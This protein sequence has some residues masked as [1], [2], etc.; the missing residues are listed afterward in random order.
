MKG[1]VFTLDALFALMIAAIGIAIVF[2]FAYTAPTPYMIQSSVATGLLST[3]GSSTIGQISGIPLAGYIIN[4]SAASNQT[5]TMQYANQYNNA[6]NGYGPSSLM[7]AYVI[8][9]NATIINGTIVAGYGN[10]YFGAG[11]TIYAINATTGS[12]IWT[13]N[14]PYNSIF[15]KEP[16]VNATLLYSGMLI[17]ATNS[18][19]VAL[20]ALNGTVIWGSNPEYGSQSTEPASTDLKT[21]IIQYGGRIIGYTFDTANSL[22]STVYSM[23]ANNGTILY[24]SSLYAN[25]VSYAAIAD[26]QYLITTAQG[27]ILLETAITSN[28]FGAATIWSATPSCGGVGYPTGISVLSNVIAYGCGATGNIISID[29]SQIFTAALPSAATGL[30]AY[31]GHIIFQ[32][33]NAVVMASTSSKVWATSMNA[34]G[35]AMSN[36]TPVASLNN[37]YSLWSG[38]YIVVQNLSTG[39]VITNTSIPYSGSINPHMVLA[40]GRLFVSRGSYLM[41]F[42]TCLGNSN[43]S[44]LSELGSLYLNGQA[45][46]ADYLLSNL[47]NNSNTAITINGTS[48]NNAAKFSGHN[49]YISTVLPTNTPQ[50]TLS[51]WLN[52]SA[53]PTNYQRIVSLDKYIAPYAGWT[54]L[55]TS[56]GTTIYMALFTS[57]GTEFD[58]GYANLNLDSW[59]NYIITYNGVIPTIYRNGVAIPTSSNGVYSSVSN[60]PL[61]IGS[62][63]SSG[64]GSTSYN[65][66]MSN[67][68][69]YNISLSQVQVSSL[70][71]EGLTGFPVLS[72]SLIGWWPLQSDANNYARSYSAGFPANVVFTSANY[73]PQSLQ[74][75]FSV[76][77]QSVPITLFNYTTGKY[78][79][80][81]IGV[82]SWK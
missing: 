24:H 48:I 62:G 74:N 42:G 63:D 5:W 38:N 55:G 51:F 14:T 58:S 4:Q 64:V 68:Q 28:T 32:T 33:S 53:Y 77:S 20:N 44:E 41:S 19:V 13:S 79:L 46:C 54:V 8:N 57:S 47:Q 29:S 39:S 15:G 35:N 76:S 31:N 34:Y 69:L 73:T 65:G 18:N 11:N 12:V 52:P 43:F 61:I 60:L 81:N 70:Y 75:S 72:S 2:Y 59:Q 10:V 3:L 27:K 21:S 45:S 26:G 36:A 56:S 23:Y 49:S 30:T 17:Y 6:G 78:K 7:L 9:A 66:M 40:Y 80:Y 1:F 22:S 37:V 25:Q 16:Y 67:V 50:F 82:Y 71:Q